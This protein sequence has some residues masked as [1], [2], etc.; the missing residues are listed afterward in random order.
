[1]QVVADRPGVVPGRS[2]RRLDDR[3]LAARI[4][5]GDERAFAVAYERHLPALIRYCRGIVLVREDAEDVAQDA[6]LAALGALRDGENPPENLRA[7]L[8]R[9][10]HNK[11]ISLLRRRREHNPLD[12]AVERPGHDVVTVAAVR[13]RLRQLVSDLRSMPHRQRSALVMRELSGLEYAEIATALRCSEAA[14]MQTVFEARTALMQCEQ[15]RELEC[16]G[17]QRLI[18]DGDRRSIRA[19]RVRA[20]IRSCDLCLSFERGIAARSRDMRLL[21][22]VV[23]VKGGLATLIGALCMRGRAALAPRVLGSKAAVAAVAVAVGGVA[24][25]NRVESRPRHG[26][27]AAPAV[28]AVA[29]GPSSGMVATEVAVAVRAA[30]SPTRAPRVRRVRPS[31]SASPPAVALKPRTIAPGVPAAS[32]AGTRVSSPSSAVAVPAGPAGAQTPA[33]TAKVAAGVHVDPRPVAVS[34]GASASVGDASPPAG[35]QAPSGPLG[36]SAGANASTGTSSSSAPGQL[37]AGR[38]NV[39]IAAQVP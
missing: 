21:F 19:R 17:I 9:V 30:K 8:Y 31:T 14:A 36:V 28:R 18:S 15:G 32:Q 29:R 35:G 7:W 27:S 10:A 25:V 4:S 2:I 23:V 38:A 20:H 24:T 11:A 16:T 37:G 22:P 13:A 12:D 1:M 3:R 39:A 6:M 34:A 33:P 5:D 26:R